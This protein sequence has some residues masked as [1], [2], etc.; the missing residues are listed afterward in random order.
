MEPVRVQIKYRNITDIILN[1]NGI[2]FPT[3][4]VHFR[5]SYRP[6]SLL[7]VALVGAY[8]YRV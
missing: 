8:A 1:M 3:F 2:Y 7:V 4:S 6:V 5:A